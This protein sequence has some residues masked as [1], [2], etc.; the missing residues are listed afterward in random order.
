MAILRSNEFFS[1]MKLKVLQK[2]ELNIKPV[3]VHLNKV[4]YKEGDPVNGFY[5]VG[6]GSVRYGKYMSVEKSK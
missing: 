2:L 6:E 1:K 5:L 3:K 4:I